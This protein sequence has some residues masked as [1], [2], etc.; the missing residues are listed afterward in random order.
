MIAATAISNDLAVHT[1]N[2]AGFA[3]I[4]GLTVIAVPHPDRPVT[5]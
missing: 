5:P 1:C 4:D 3:G 2:P